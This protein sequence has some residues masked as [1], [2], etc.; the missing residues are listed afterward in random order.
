MPTHALAW[1]MVVIALGSYA[2][3]ADSG[4]NGSD[5]SADPTYSWMFRCDAQVPYAHNVILEPLGGNAIAAAFQAGSTEG[6]NMHLRFTV[7]PDQVVTRPKSVRLTMV[8]GCHLERFR[9]RGSEYRQ[10]VGVGP[11]AALEREHTAAPF[12]LCC[13][14]SLHSQL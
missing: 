8:A 10:A 1:P 3:A 6:G 4:V 14:E 7:S 2:A 9:D 12:V 13:L 11:R 5:Q